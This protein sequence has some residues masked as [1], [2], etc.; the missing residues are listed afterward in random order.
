[1]QS[2]NKAMIELGLKRNV[3]PA[4]RNYDKSY[5]IISDKDSGENL[6]GKRPDAQ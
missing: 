4:Q 2:K 3:P 1:M 5:K 6:Y